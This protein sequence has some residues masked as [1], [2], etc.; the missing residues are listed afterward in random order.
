MFKSGLFIQE[1]PVV[2]IQCCI[3]S[4]QQYKYLC[5]KGSLPTVVTCSATQAI[6]SVRSFIIV[7]FF[8][9]KWLLIVIESLISQTILRYYCNVV[10]R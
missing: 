1:Q 10:F 7:Y 2:Y 3:F 6:Y 8:F 5:V 4:P 9:G